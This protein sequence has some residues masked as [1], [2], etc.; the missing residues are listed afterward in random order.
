MSHN[1]IDQCTMGSAVVQLHH[2]ITHIHQLATTNPIGSEPKVSAP[3]VHFLAA[4]GPLRSHQCLHRA[5][6]DGAYKGRKR[7]QFCHSESAAKTKI[8]AAR[9]GEV[10][11]L[12]NG[13]GAP[14]H[15]RICGSRHPLF[16][17]LEGGGRQRRMAPWPDKFL[18]RSVESTQPR[19]HRPATTTRNTA[20][21]QK[22]FS[23]F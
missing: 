7:N 18:K 16:R 22:V 21:Q 6:E 4:E 3:S 12:Q 20:T 15:R 11:R 17:G 13:G 14:V 1:G 2:R 19:A 9:R 10:T 8:E 5:E 23:S